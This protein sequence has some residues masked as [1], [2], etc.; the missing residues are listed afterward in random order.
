M[1][2]TRLAV[3]GLTAFKKRAEIDFSGLDLF[4][5]TGP[6]GAGKTT[7]VDAISYALFGQVPRVNNDVKQLI[8]QGEERLF[9]ELEFSSGGDSYRIHR[10][11]GHKGLPNVQ[12]ERQDDA[13]GEWMPLADKAREAT[14]MVQ[15][16]LGMDYDGFVRSILLP[17]GQFQQGETFL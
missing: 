8:S 6:T 15:Q 5:I 1:R 3:Q 17:Q 4:A 2:P 9:V 14:D 7:L 10:S 13:S 12:L 16:T 11:T